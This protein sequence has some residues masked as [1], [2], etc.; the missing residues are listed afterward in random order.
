MIVGIPKE[1]ADGERRVALVPE[2]VGKLKGVQV[3]VEK[4]AGQ[5]VDHLHY[6]LLAG[7]PMQWPPG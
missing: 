7:R 1:T 3:L 5:S 4:G 6:H 2:L